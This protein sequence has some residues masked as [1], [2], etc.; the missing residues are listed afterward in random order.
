AHEQHL[1]E[2]LSDGLLNIP[3]V[4][5]HRPKSLAA[6][7]FANVK[8]P[9]YVGVVSVS[10][11]GYDPQ[12]VAAVLDASFGVQVRA[13][14]HC[15]PLMHKVLGSFERGGTIRFSIGPF[16]TQEDIETAIRAV[17]QFASGS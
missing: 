8:A 10:I 9:A 7:A 4:I 12:E 5:V 15:A 17:R 16:N 2:R 6:V 1:T 13:G 14:L 3:G 11:E